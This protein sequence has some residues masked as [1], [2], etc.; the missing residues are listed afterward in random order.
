MDR[1]DLLAALADAEASMP[2]TVWPGAAP[3]EIA[4][5]PAPAQPRKGHKPRW[6]GRPRKN[7]KQARRERSGLV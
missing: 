2:P 4:P 6:T 7:S 3:E 1:L 5:P